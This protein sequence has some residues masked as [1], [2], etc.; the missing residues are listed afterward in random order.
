M[1][2][3]KLSYWIN[4]MEGEIM[5]EMEFYYSGY[6]LKINYLMFYLTQIC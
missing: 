5:S 6:N 2:K 1:L 4:Q 3:S